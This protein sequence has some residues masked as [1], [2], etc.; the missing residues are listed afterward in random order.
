MACI[1][2]PNLQTFSW[3]ST[4]SVDID[5]VVVKYCCRLFCVFISFSCFAVRVCI[6][7]S[8]LQFGLHLSH[9]I[10]NLSQAVI[11]YHT[12]LM[13]RILFMYLIIIVLMFFFLFNYFELAIYNADQRPTL[14]SSCTRVHNCCEMDCRFR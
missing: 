1:H 10:D 11:Q 3:I 14:P 9:D 5:A 12:F 7:F 2:S 13:V 4:T 6:L 8:K